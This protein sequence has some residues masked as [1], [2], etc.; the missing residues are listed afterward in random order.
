[1]EK[2][3]V[4]T[5]VDSASENAVT[6]KTEESPAVSKESTEVAPTVAEEIIGVIC[7]A[8]NEDTVVAKDISEATPDATEESN[9][10]LS[11]SLSF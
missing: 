2:T 1:M 4:K 8:D 5:P 3:E 7:G 11:F 10:I 9:Q 6:E